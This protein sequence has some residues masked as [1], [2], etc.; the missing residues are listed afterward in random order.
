MSVSGDMELDHKTNGEERGERFGE[1]ENS[2]LMEGTD[3]RSGSQGSVVNSAQSHGFIDLDR[4]LTLTSPP[5][6]TAS[7]LTTDVKQGQKEQTHRKTS[8]K[9][10]LNAELAGGGGK[11]EL[12]NGGET[13]AED[14]PN[15]AAQTS[16][17]LPTQRDLISEE[18][19]PSSPSMVQLRPTVHAIFGSTAPPAAPHRA[20]PKA[21][22]VESTTPSAREL[23]VKIN[24]VAA[25]LNKSSHQQRAHEKTLGEGPGKQKEDGKKTDVKADR[26][27][28]RDCSDHVRQGHTHSGLYL[29][30]PDPSSGNSVHVLCEMEESGGG[31][32]V[33]QKRQDGSYRDGFGL[34]DGGEFWLGNYLIH[35]L[36]RD[37]SMELRVELEDF[38]GVKEYA[39][40]E[41]FKVAS[42][43]MRFRLSV[44][45]YSGTAGDALL[46][47]A[48]YNHNNRAF[49]TPDRDNDR[50]PSGNCGA[51][52]SSGW[53]F[54]ACMAANLNGRYYKGRYKG[55]RDGIYWG[56]WHNISTEYYPTNERLSF[57]T[58][59]MM[60]RPKDFKP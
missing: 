1:I 59:R 11:K 38:E 6:F 24:Q 50:Y 19:S 17:I 23:R 51:Y 22:A 55:V 42:E 46:F 25:F 21:P 13:N 2:E 5:P 16:T 8:I 40:Y 7:H 39:Q 18:N 27:V 34:L 4:P 58:V 26:M 33:L 9:D 3:S 57:K 30:T 36:T 31:W 29:V 37:R 12:E 15:K 32:T 44:D 14:E 20:G 35:L 10:Q 53:W 52:Y 48:E 56:T 60:I 41:L 28:V 45:G 43:R 54:D 47:N 49:T